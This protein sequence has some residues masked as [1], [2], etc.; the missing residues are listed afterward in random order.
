MK[1]ALLVATGVSVLCACAA[2]R[3]PIHAVPDLGS[4]RIV[5]ISVGPLVEERAFPEAQ[6]P[7][8]QYVQHAAEQTLARKGYEPRL[9]L[10]PPLVRLDAPL[11][12]APAAS[13]P[14]LPSRYALWVAA[15]L[16]ETDSSD[17]GLDTRLRLAGVLVDTEAGEVLWRDR[18]EAESSISGAG[19]AVL[20]PSIRTYEAVSQAMNKLLLTLP[21]SSGDTP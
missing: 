18:A 4:R 17:I 5:E 2:Q 16:M 20:N 21:D 13:L 3:M 6:L 8:A 9:V 19:F 10:D 15:E 1:R 7:L 14:P 11:V 12:D